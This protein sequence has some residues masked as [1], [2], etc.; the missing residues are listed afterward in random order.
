MEN[1]MNESSSLP[2]SPPSPAV[3][4]TQG[5]AGESQ[6]AAGPTKTLETG[7]KPFD[8]QQALADLQ[9]ALAADTSKANGAGPE[10]SDAEQKT[11]LSPKAREADGGGK[12]HYDKIV[13]IGALVAAV[14][15]TATAIATIYMASSM[16]SSAR[17]GE[18][19]KSEEFSKLDAVHGEVQKNFNESQKLQQESVL[20]QRSSATSLDQTAAQV[21]KLA[22]AYQGNLPTI[23]TVESVTLGGLPLSLTNGS[24]EVSSFAGCPLLMVK[25]RGPSRGGNLKVE[26][27]MEGSPFSCPVK[28]LPSHIEPGADSDLPVELDDCLRSGEI[29]E[30][31]GSG[32]LTVRV[33]R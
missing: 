11:A 33:T 10:S 24:Y 32:W 31:D 7:A 18:K 4:E 16:W 13:A 9:Q 12:H 21:T 3:P 14:A 27:G 29:T 22:G 1:A 5:L 19:W 25:L 30:C 2:D 6:A 20:L 8:L 28:P 26:G 15:A 17:Q 23:A